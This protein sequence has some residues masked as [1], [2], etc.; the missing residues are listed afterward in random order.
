MLPFAG[1]IP[2]TNYTFPEMRVPS[3]LTRWVCACL[4]AL[5]AVTCN[6]PAL[7]Q[8]SGDPGFTSPAVRLPR[9]F[10]RESTRV[11]GARINYMIGG[12]GPVV[13]LLHGYAQTGHMWMTLMPV[14]ARTHTVIV[15]DL[16][17]MGAS[18]RTAGGYDKK[19]LA[20]DIRSLVRQLDEGRVRIVGHDIGMMVAYAYA[21]QFPEEVDRIVLMDAFLPGIGDWRDA[22]LLR[23]MQTLRFYGATAS[24]RVRGGER[25]YFDHFWDGLA[26]NRERS[27]PEMDRRI[28]ARAYS[29]ENGMRG[30]FEAYL[31]FDQDAK[32][33][34][35]FAAVRLEM[36]VL[37]LSGEKASGGILVAQAR[38]VASDVT[39]NVIKGAGHWLMEESPNQVIPAIVSFLRPL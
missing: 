31:S 9:G 21:A 12:R 32:D 38:R 29:G 5:V 22:W 30:G 11:N 34:A 36:P 26:A 20:R 18:Q 27:I 14:L 13:V 15:P 33:F 10:N 16:R 24:A 2:L 23:E 37:V 28:Y 35:G 3:S 1:P 25:A 6:W 39:G 8:P 17:G 4:L 19:N 7:A